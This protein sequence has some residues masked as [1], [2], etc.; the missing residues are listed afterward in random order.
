M[1]EYVKSLKHMDWCSYIYRHG[2]AFFKLFLAIVE[3]ITYNVVKNIQYIYLLVSM[4]YIHTCV[5]T[6][7]WEENNT[8]LK[9]YDLYFLT[10]KNA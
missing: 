7:I 1:N 2:T 8:L 6:C 4:I 9:L 10:I 5:Y 3:H